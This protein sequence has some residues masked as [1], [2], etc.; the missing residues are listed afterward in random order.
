MHFH[1]G[2]CLGNDSLSYHRRHDVVD[3]MDKRQYSAL[4]AAA[5]SRHQQ[6]LLAERCNSPADYVQFAIL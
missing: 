3:T 4:I 6:F 1:T 2:G 5:L